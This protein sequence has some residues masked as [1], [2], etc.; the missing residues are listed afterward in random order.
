MED[1]A[2]LVATT[3]G[4][5]RH[6]SFAAA[7]RRCR[8]TTAK[9]NALAKEARA[10]AQGAVD[11]NVGYWS[12]M[13]I[14]ITARGRGQMDE[15]LAALQTALSAAEKRGNAYRRSY[16]LY[17][18]SQLYLAMKEPRRAL[19]ASRQSFGFAEAAGS[20]HGWRRRGWPSPRRW[21]SSPIRRASSRR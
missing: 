8:A 14:G 6:A 17:Q 11:P 9:A 20:A 13:M 16:A 1:D 15:S 12:E 3:C 21:S 7:S 19:E 18:I 10:L 5:P 2:A 4:S